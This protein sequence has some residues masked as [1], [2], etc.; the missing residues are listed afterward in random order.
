M[1]FQAD[2]YNAMNAKTALQK[3]YF[4]GTTIRT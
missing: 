4:I 2:F 1:L 3:R